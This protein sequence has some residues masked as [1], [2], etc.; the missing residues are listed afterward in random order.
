[1]PARSGG[2]PGRSI[3]RSRTGRR[4]TTFTQLPDAFCGGRI[5][6]S[7]PVAGLMLSTSAS[8]VMSGYMSSTTVAFWPT[9]TWVEVGLLEVG[10]DPGPAVGDERE[11]RR[12]RLDLLAEL[13]LEVDDHAGARRLDL[14]VGEIERGAVA[15]RLLLAHRGVAGRSAWSGL[16]PSA[17]STRAMRWCS[18]ARRSRACCSSLSACSTA[19]AALTP[20]PDSSRWRLAWVSKIRQAGSRPPWPRR[21]S[22]AGSP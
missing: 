22:R 17:A 13:Q 18:I 14:G 15:Q 9:V 19:A 5:A 2:S 11:Q 4:C 1:M 16:P 21:G 6:N 10:L 8:Q 3:S 20:R 7:A 12:L